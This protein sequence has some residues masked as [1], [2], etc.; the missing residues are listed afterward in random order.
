M[1]RSN[2]VHLTKIAAKQYEIYRNL[3]KYKLAN[4]LLRLLNPSTFRGQR[5][6]TNKS[7]RDNER[8]ITG[9]LGQVRTY[10]TSTERVR[11]YKNNQNLP[12][13]ITKLILSSWI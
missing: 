12:L 4:E 1:T 5:Y 11:L 7:V 9:L 10:Y 6:F 2:A 8:A 3:Q 13:S